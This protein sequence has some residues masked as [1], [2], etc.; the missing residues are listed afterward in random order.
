MP[1]FNDFLKLFRVEQIYKNSVIFIPLIFSI[2]LLDIK[3]FFLSLIGFDILCLTSFSYY[4]INDVIDAKKD[5]FHPEKKDRP[6]ASG[7]F[8]PWFAIALAIIF[9]I[10]SLVSSYYI[11]IMFF[12]SV[13]ALFLLSVFYSSFAR[14]IIFLDLVIISIN[15]VIKTNSGT[16]IINTPISYWLILCTF[17]ISLFLVSLKRISEIR[18]KESVKYR[19]SLE[20]ANE[21]IFVFLSTISITSVFI[22]FSIYCILLNHHLLI[23]SIPVALYIALSF[24]HQL[25]INPKFVRNPEKFIFAPRYLF[26]ILLWLFSVI[27]SLYYSKI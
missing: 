27:F 23:I 5:M 19:S 3:S 12:L 17:F 11:S 25:D 9:L 7:R 1:K 8:K 13:I 15:F 2:H 24:Y 4:I 21:K 18:L 20:G 10:I 14:K 22:F 16:F 26:A 6:I